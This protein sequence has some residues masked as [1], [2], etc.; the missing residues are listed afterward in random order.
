MSSAADLQ[1]RAVEFARTGD[2]G[3]HALEANLEL[4]KE[5]PSNQGAWTRL[6][7]CYI[8]V[9]QLDEATAALDA[10]LQLNPQNTIARNLQGEVT[11]RR[12]GFSDA[13]PAR[14]AKPS[15][16]RAGKS[17]RGVSSG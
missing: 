13:A 6:A 9:G 2:F 7:R 15:R 3:P 12:V 10:V 1:Q 5:D 4:T 14:G 17:S 8:E 16:S 11:K